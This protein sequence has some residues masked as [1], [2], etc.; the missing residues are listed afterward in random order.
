LIK[1]YVLHWVVV[2]N[3]RQYCGYY[4]C[5]PASASACA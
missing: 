5:T 2:V 3:P 1:L 4:F